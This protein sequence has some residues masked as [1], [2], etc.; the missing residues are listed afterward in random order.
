MARQFLSVTIID[1][2]QETSSSE[3]TSTTH[4]EVAKLF[5]GNQ[6]STFCNQLL[7]DN[8]FLAWCQWL[9][10]VNKDN[11]AL[12]GVWA[13]CSSITGHKSTHGWACQRL[14]PLPIQNFHSPLTFRLLCANTQH[15]RFGGG[16][17]TVPRVLSP[18]ASSN[19]TQVHRVKSSTLT[20]EPRLLLNH[21]CWRST[22]VMIFM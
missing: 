20:Y 13:G 19:Q 16:S 1:A 3:M 2:N 6:W 12:Y 18:A 11:S 10:D 14:P 22:L 5:L 4:S 17:T 15:C 8:Q 7:T 9:T 21:G